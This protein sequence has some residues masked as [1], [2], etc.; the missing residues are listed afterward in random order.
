MVLGDNAHRL[1]VEQRAAAQIRQ[2]ETWCKQVVVDARGGAGD[3]A[4]RAG[5]VLRCVA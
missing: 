3:S 1:A 4:G 5:C 2:P